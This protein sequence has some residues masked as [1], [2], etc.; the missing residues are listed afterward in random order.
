MMSDI[1]LRPVKMGDAQF[2][3]ELRNDPEVCKWS[4]T[5]TPQTDFRAHCHWLQMRV[6]GKPGEVLYVVQTTRG[7]PVGL[8]WM[9]FNPNDLDKMAEIHYR[10]AP[11]ERRKGYAFQAVKSLIKSIGHRHAKFKCPIIEGNIASEALARK[12][13][14]HPDNRM[15]ISENDERVIVDWV[16]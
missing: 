8:V 12:L 10:I 14:L 2:L 13:G 9:S 7:V 16:Q 4:Q 11:Q 3:F 1:L 6:D 15:Q 5:N